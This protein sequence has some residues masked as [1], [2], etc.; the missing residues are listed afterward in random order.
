MKWRYY[1]SDHAKGRGMWVLHRKWVDR[2]NIEQVRLCYEES[3]WWIV[4]ESWAAHMDLGWQ[5]QPG[6]DHNREGDKVRCCK[7]SASS[8]QQQART[9]INER[10]FE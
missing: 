7:V 2:T 3:E 4:L 5:A 9:S 1:A 6:L 8:C 10:K